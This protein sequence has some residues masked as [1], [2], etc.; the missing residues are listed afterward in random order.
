MCFNVLLRLQDIMLHSIAK[1]STI[2]K[3]IQG[4]SLFE[5]IICR[6]TI[7]SNFEDTK[8]NKM[9]LDSH[10]RLKYFIDNVIRNKI[11]S[12]KF[13]KGNELDYMNISQTIT[14]YIA[15]QFI[16]EGDTAKVFNLM[17]N[18]LFNTTRFD[19]LKN[20]DL[21]VS[22]S[23]EVKNLLGEY[24]SILS[25][26]NGSEPPL[27][28]S[29]VSSK[30]VE[31]WSK[32]GFQGADPTR[33]FRATGYYGVKMLSKMSR[34]YTDKVRNIFQEASIENNATWYPFSTVCINIIHWIKEALAEFDSDFEF[35]FYL[36]KP[37][38]YDSVFSCLLTYILVEWHRFWR[39][40]N[41]KNIMEFGPISVEFRVKLSRLF[42]NIKDTV[43]QSKTKYAT[44]YDVVSD[45]NKWIN[46]ENGFST[47]L[48]L[49]VK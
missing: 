37:E 5:C 2:E 27:M 18:E 23:E 26:P 36:T 49:R 16:L 25:G 11:D 9:K 31:T 7:K 35:L 28:Q 42:R 41:P 46:D 32:L 44:G 43:S 30:D 17:T 21:Q 40:K 33:D 4:K 19:F 45:L 6:Q 22:K 10:I 14:N 29:K 48:E 13:D 15:N 24:W 38:L 12:R 20:D 39:A 34:D 8:I 47:V 1:S 3:T